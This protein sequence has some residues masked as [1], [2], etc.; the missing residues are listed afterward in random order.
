MY[1]DSVYAILGRESLKWSLTNTTAYVNLLVNPTTHNGRAGA[2]LLSELYMGEDP[3][4][5]ALWRLL[6]TRWIPG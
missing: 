4:E 3:A 2:A 6:S 5:G 1:I